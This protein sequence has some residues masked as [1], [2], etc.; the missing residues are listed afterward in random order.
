MVCDIQLQPLT[1][2]KTELRNTSF[3]IRFYKENLK[4]EVDNLR[5]GILG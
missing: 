3:S 2:K 5:I 1:Y 4:S